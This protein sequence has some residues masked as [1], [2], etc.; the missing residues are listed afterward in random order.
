M[1]KMDP[2]VSFLFKK[3]YN[4]QYRPWKPENSKFYHYRKQ[5]FNGYWVKAKRKITSNNKLI[6]FINKKLPAKNLYYSISRWSNPEKVGPRNNNNR[7]LGTNLI[8]DFDIIQNILDQD[9]FNKRK[10]QVIEFKNFLKD[11]FNFT[12]FQYLFTGNKGFHLYVLDYNNFD[13]YEN[14]IKNISDNKQKFWDIEHIESSNRDFLC[15]EIEEKGFPVDLN[16]INDLMRVVRLPGTL[17]GSTGLQSILTHSEDEFI[18]LNVERSFTIDNDYQLKLIF[19]HDV[20]EFST[21]DDVIGPYKRGDIKSIASGVGCFLILKSYAKLIS[22]PDEIDT[23]DLKPFI[24]LENKIRWCKNCNI[25][26]IE[27]L[28]CP[29]CNSHT[30]LVR[31]TGVG[32]SRPAFEINK[33]RIKAIIDS[34]YGKDVGEKLIPNDKIILLNRVPRI[35][36][37]QKEVI[38]DGHVIGRIKFD[39]N[40]MKFIFIP[41]IEGARR[42]HKINAGKWIKLKKGIMLSI[43]KFLSHK[44]ILKSN[45]TDVEFNDLVFIIQNNNLIGIGKI[46]NQLDCLDDEKFIQIT[47]LKRKNENNVYNG[48]QNWNQVIKA[49]LKIIQKYEDDTILFIKSIKKLYPNLK[50]TVPFSGGKDSLVTV[51]LTMKALDDFSINYV[52]SEIEFPETNEYVYRCIKKL[53]LQNKYIQL[54]EPKNLKVISELLGPPQVDNQWCA[55][56]YKFGPTN[57]F[58]REKFPNG[59]LSFVGLRSYESNLRTLNYRLNLNP[60]LPDALSVHPIYDWNALLIWLYIFKNNFPINPIYELYGRER[61][62]CWICPYQDLSNLQLLKE[63]HKDLWNYLLEILD[64]YKKKYNLPDEWIT[65]GLWKWAD[66]PLQVKNWI[67]NKKIP[68]SWLDNIKSNEFKIINIIEEKYQTNNKYRISGNINNFI[69]LKEIKNI[70]NILGKVKFDENNNSLEVILNEGKLVIDSIGNFSLQSK[71]NENAKIQLINFKSTI[72]KLKKCIGCLN[73]ISLCKHEAIF[74]K[75]SELPPRIDSEKCIHCLECNKWCPVLRFSII[76]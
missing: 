39:D 45:L 61:C 3:Y 26:I 70:L 24:W 12:T 28:V 44:D 35:K 4:R 73:C 46:K 47:S 38:I 41:N 34:E 1:R 75:N 30:F 5:L 71:N 68:L 14:Y 13:F 60:W 48:G 19:L 72:F 50:V 64:Q 20:P 7:C 15:K 11:T 17:H 32:D 65:S 56:I 31:L 9:E 67:K 62:G 2:I 37:R 49:N 74:Q 54:N 10:N 51:G 18:K 63:D 40:L 76:D 43:F 27:M 53:G 59:C 55:K 23:D 21:K 69:N 25:P 42:L 8:F 36:T 66:P 58:Y 33:K 22:K 6:A 16:V 52:K 29:I 57:K